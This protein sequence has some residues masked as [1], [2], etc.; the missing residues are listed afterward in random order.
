MITNCP[1]VLLVFL[2]VANSLG[3]IEGQKTVEGEAG[4]P[5]L[6]C[7][8]YLSSDSESQTNQPWVPRKTRKQGESLRL[9]APYTDGA[10]EPRLPASG[11]E[12]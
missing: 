7:I 5:R 6:M 8:G 2:V 4:V 12:Q 1:S 11:A 3:V 9:T 10:Q